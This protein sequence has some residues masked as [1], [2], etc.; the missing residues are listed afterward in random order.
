[1]K[2]YI[3]FIFGMFDDHEDIEYFCTDILGDSPVIKSVRF[4]IENSQNIIVIF[5]S[6]MDYK[7]MSNELFAILTNENIKFY[8]I[9]D[10]DNLVTAHLPYEVKEFIFKPITDNMIIKMDYSKE[11]AKPILDLDSLLDKIEEMGIESLTPEE[12]NFLDNFDK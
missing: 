11:N 7:T 9:F 2:T 10:R 5:D 3:L 4:V 1:M 8:F 12:K 6:E